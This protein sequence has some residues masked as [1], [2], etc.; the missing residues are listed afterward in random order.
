MSYKI[1]KNIDIFITMIIICLYILCI[2]TFFYRSAMYCYNN[3]KKALLMHF[4][5]IFILIISIV[6]LLYFIYV[7][8][9]NFHGILERFKIYEK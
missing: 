8:D 1:I 3:N 2:F 9:L 6:L 4:A 5:L 7:P